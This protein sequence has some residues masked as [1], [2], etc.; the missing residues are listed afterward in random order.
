MPRQ[1][2]LTKMRG[3]YPTKLDGETL[4]S[5]FGIHPK[6]PHNRRLHCTSKKDYIK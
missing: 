4:T 2:Y 3:R 6:Q 5:R 1:S